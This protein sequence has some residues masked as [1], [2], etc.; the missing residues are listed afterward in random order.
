ML[1]NTIMEKDF[2]SSVW[3]Y[4]KSSDFPTPKTLGYRKLKQ[5]SQYLYFT[6]IHRILQKTKTKQQRNE[7]Y[8]FFQVHVEQWQKAHVSFQKKSQ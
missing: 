6:S 8:M 4:D 1:T 2:I 7:E 3:E 5:P